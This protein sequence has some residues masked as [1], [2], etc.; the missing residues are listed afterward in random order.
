MKTKL[1]LFI[2]FWPRWAFVALCWLFSACG[3]RGLLFVALCRLLIAGVLLVAFLAGQHRLYGCG[4]QLLHY[5]GSA[6]VT[7]GL[8][9]EGL[10]VV[11]QGLSCLS[12]CTIFPV[13][14]LNLCPLHWQADFY[15]P[16]HQGYLQINL[17]SVFLS[18][19]FVSPSSMEVTFNK[20]RNRV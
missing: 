15:P 9:S 8:K 7:H 18:S 13:W 1:C 16:C 3:D 10:V 4:L 19:T 20:P 5:P 17:I 2:N 12:A 14:E 11:V 6:V